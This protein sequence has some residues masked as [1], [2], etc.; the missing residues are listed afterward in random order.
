MK[1]PKAR[2][3]FKM[4]RVLKSALKVLVF[5]LL[6]AV[7][8]GYFV[9]IPSEISGTSMSPTLVEHDQ[10]LVNTLSEIDRFDILV[11]R[12]P[13]MKPVVKRVI[14]MPGET[15]YY[16][17]DQLYV[18]GKQIKEPFL[19]FYEK[20]A[21]SGLFTSNFTLSEVTTKPIIPK[22]HYF[23]MGDNRRYS[24]DSRHYGTISESSIIGE[25]QLLYYPM[26]RFS[27]LSNTKS[28]NRE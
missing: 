17:D 5:L 14:G 6:L 9:F 15:F 12:D 25:A 2:S 4:K 1:T 24:Y 20:D 23:V 22:D 27:F 16:H 21:N 11:F 3:H 7:A 28:K 10:L 26:D 8:I 18:D 19:N 13:G